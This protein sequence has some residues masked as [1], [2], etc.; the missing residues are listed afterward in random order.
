MA[1][2]QKLKKHV[3]DQFKIKP[4]PYVEKQ[5]IVH[6]PRY[7]VNKEAYTTAMYASEY[8]SQKCFC[9]MCQRIVPKT[10]IERN[11]VQKLPEYGW[12]QMYL[13]LCL[14]CSK[15]YILLRNNHAVWEK[16]INSILGEDVEDE[17]TVWIPIGN[18]ELAFT[19]IHLAEIQA[20]LELEKDMNK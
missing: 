1:N 16:F 13:S 18:K 5:Q 12:D 3:R 11:D 9:Q 20:I 6:V 19:A 14:N 7:P 8:N 15:D 10:H 2:L 17:E 4:N